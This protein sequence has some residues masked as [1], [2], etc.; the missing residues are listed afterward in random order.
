MEMNNIQLP[1][2]S[3]VSIEKVFSVLPRHISLDDVVAVAAVT[4]VLWTLWYLG[5][6]FER[7]DPHAY[8]MYE[9]PQEKMGAIGGAKG[10]RNGAEK[11]DQIGA[12][13]VIFWGSQS[14]TAERFANRLS[15]EIRQRFGKKALAADVSDYETTFIGEIPETKLAIFVVSTFGEGDP[16]DNLQDSWS[17]LET[18][19]GSP[20]ANL[21]YAALGLGNS[22]YKYYNAVVD[23][24][25]AKLNALGAKCLLPVAYADDA[26]GQTE[27]HYL[28]FKA[29]V[30]QH[31]KTSMDLE[32]YDPV[33]EPL[34]QV[35][36]DTSLEPIAVRGRALGSQA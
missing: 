1:A 2:L 19:K 30:F 22:N 29:N 5:L 6:L 26:Q 15:K 23:V 9:R 10:T 3:L 16:S 27:E 17:W 31:F 34:L 8:K 21:K 24:V 7:S 28:E 12:D 18:A 4:A 32:E 35:V 33:Y 14:G 11:L 13:I 25:A 36:E 20:F